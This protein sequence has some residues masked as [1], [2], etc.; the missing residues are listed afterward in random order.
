MFCKK[1][2]KLLPT[3]ANFCQICG[4]PQRE[5]LVVEEPKWETCELFLSEEKACGIFSRPVMKF[6]AKAYSEKGSYCAGVSEQFLGDG[7]HGSSTIPY[8]HKKDMKFAVTALE[9]LEGKLLK[10]GW[11]F[12]GTFGD[13]FW[14]KRFRRRV[15]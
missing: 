15:K 10:D 2:G 4:T 9:K 11:E 3:D 6:W 12:L 13:W 5:G 7:I 8:M 1:C 14:A